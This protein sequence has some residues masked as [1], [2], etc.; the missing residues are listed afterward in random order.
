[1]NGNRVWLYCRALN[2]INSAAILE[3]QRRGLEACAQ[4]HGLE[5]VGCSSDVGGAAPAERPGLLAFRAAMEKKRVDIL[6]PFNLSCLGRDLGE[7]VQYWSS[8]REHGVRLYTVAEGEVYLDM[9]TLFNQM[10]PQ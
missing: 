4:E 2:G 3:T 8:L 1:M 5:I 6:M 10:F 9:R 7:V